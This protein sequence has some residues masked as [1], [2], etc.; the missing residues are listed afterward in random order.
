MVGLA[1][2]D[3]EDEPNDDELRTEAEAAG[4]DIDAWAA[5]IRAKVAAY[6]AA[7]RLAGA[8][9]VEPPGPP[10]P[11]PRSRA[12]AGKARWSL[13][14]GLLTVSLVGLATL[15]A[16]W[17][18]PREASIARKYLPTRQVTEESVSATGVPLPAS[19]APRH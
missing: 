1:L 2:L 18:M 13:V 10:P 16:H 6:A 9:D 15:A 4:I 19:S 3:A 8:N 5:E 14:M 7:E 12:G 11:L 17:A